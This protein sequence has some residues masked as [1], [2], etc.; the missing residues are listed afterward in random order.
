MTT[1]RLQLAGGMLGIVLLAGTTTAAL[2]QHLSENEE[3]MVRLINGNH[4]VESDEKAKI[5]YLY[6]LENFAEV[7][8]AMH[9]DNVPADDASLVP[10]LVRGLS[11]KSV[12]DVME[13]L[14][15]FYAAHPEKLE[16]PV[17]ETIYLELALPNS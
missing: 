2:G 11:G 12:E 14:D 3:L 13:E 9:G 15:A 1:R 16:R 6:G 7:E 10:V 4:W 8:Q 5:G 17:L